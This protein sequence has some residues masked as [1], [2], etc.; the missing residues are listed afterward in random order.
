MCPRSEAP[1]S[2]ATTGC[3]TR[4]RSRPASGDEGTGR[5][6]RPSESQSRKNATILDAGLEALEIAHRLGVTMGL[7]TDLLGETQPLQPR[8]RSAARS[9]RPRR[10]CGRCGS[11][12]PTSAGSRAAS[13][14]SPP[15]AFGD[16][17]VS[18]VDPPADIV[19]FA[20]VDALLSDVIQA[21]R[22]AI[23]SITWRPGSASPRNSARRGGSSSD[24]VIHRATA[25]A[26]SVLLAPSSDM[27]ANLDRV[28]R[29][30]PAGRRFLMAALTSPAAGG[31]TVRCRRWRRCWRGSG[32]ST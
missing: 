1:T 28:A 22:V 7:G 19:A 16:L 15:G 6:V 2:A 5:G 14:S 11:R 29:R 9:N 18:P 3:S 27:A 13:G 20:D 21:G 23:R 32:S 24:I 25:A 8:W 31:D 12:T 30:R 26:A 4:P 17:V 10:S